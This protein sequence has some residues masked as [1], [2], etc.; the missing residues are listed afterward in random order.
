MFVNVN[1]FVL[2]F[3]KLY[4]IMRSYSS[5]RVVVASNLAAAI[6]ECQQFVLERLE[7]SGN[8]E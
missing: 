8:E 7:M 4:H 1:I 6:K 3:F 5:E 2:A